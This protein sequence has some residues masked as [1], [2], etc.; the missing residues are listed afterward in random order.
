MGERKEVPIPFSGPMVRAI[1]DGTKTQTRRVI[2]PQPILSAENEK[3]VSEAW[4]AGFISVKC[5]Y[6]HVGDRLWVK[7]ALISSAYDDGEPCVKYEA[8][9]HIHDDAVW[10]WK[11]KYLPSMFMPRG[12][13]R[14]TLE[15]TDVRVERLQSISANDCRAEGHPVD[16]GRSL[17]QAVHDDAA[18][19]WYRDLWD[20]L[21]AERGFGWD[22]NPWVW[23]ISFTAADAAG[24]RA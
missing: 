22:V 11:R 21:N 14:I 8:D 5:P 10:V 15:I 6:G 17:D 20:S 24:G 12:L 2:K 7:E 3:V 4:R 23:V 16:A 18:L 19:D 13:S 1:L 9:G